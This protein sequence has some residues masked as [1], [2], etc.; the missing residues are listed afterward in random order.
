MNAQLER[1]RNFTMVVHPQAMVVEPRHLVA[2]KANV[3]IGS[4][5]KGTGAALIEKIKRD[6]S[7]P[8]PLVRDM[9]EGGVARIVS[10][11]S[12]LG[13]NTFIDEDLY[14]ETVDRSS[15]AFVEGAQGYSLGVHRQ[16]WPYCTSREISPSQIMSDCAL[17]LIGDRMLVYGTLRTFPIRVANRFNE[18]NEMIGTSGAWYADQAELS[19]DELGLDPEFTTVTKL[20]RRV[21][22]FSFMQL[23]QAVRLCRPA[24]LFLNFCNYLGVEDEVEQAQ[25]VEDLCRQIDRTSAEATRNAGRA[26][27]VDLLGYGPAVTDIRLR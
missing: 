9:D 14:N 3:S 13:V 26:A 27:T 16:F 12:A 10:R 23:A 7:A 21:F 15:L 5:M 8:S 20:K 19:W 25:L 6:P 24:S 17:P 18:K 1:P 11:L 22:S 4:T 2:E